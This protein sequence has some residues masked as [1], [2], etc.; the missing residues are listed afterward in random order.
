MADD[1][2]ELRSELQQVNTQLS[3]YGRM[4]SRQTDVLEALTNE[5]KNLHET[6]REKGRENEDL[7]KTVESISKHVRELNQDFAD[8]YEGLTPQAKDDKGVQEMFAGIEKKISTIEKTLYTD[9]LTQLRN[10]TGL[11]NDLQNGQGR[12]VGMTLDIDHFKKINDTKGHDQ[13]DKVLRNTAA[14]IKDV[15]AQLG[16]TRAVRAYRMG[17]EEI[18]VLVQVRGAERSTPKQEQEFVQALAEKMRTEIEKRGDCTVSI[19]VADKCV[20]LPLNDPGKTFDVFG[21]KHLYEAKENGRNRVEGEPEKLE[22]A[23]KEA[24]EQAAGKGQG[25]G[26]GK[27]DKAEDKGCER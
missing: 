13:G 7:T 14:T 16:D 12:F 17:G 8:F 27:D 1:I 4:F 20:Q 9:E 6:I 21:D 19:G 25:K 11:K 24:Q 23:I 22:K 15:C 18:G 10:R 2:T 26:D 3:F 5:V